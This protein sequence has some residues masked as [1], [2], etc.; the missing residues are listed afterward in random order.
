MSE[1]PVAPKRSSISPSNLQRR[2][3]CPGSLLAE[4]GLPE[5]GDPKDALKGTEL[6]DLDEK[7]PEAW[8][9]IPERD[10]QLLE[11]NKGLRDAFLTEQLSKRGVNPH[12]PVRVFKEHE[13]YFCDELGMPVEDPDEIPGHPDIIYYFP[14]QKLAFIFDSKFGGLAVPKAYMNLQLRSYAVMFSD[15]Y[16]VDT[17]VA[18]ITQPMLQEPDDFHAVEFKGDEM[19]KYRG[20]ILQVVAACQKPDA[21]RIPSAEACLHCKAKAHCA[22]AVSVL[23][24]LSM[25]TVKGLSIDE[26]EDIYDEYVAKSKKVIDAIINRMHYLA[27]KGALKRHRLGRQTIERKVVDSAE[28]FNKCFEAGG[29]LHSDFEEAQKEWNRV[30]EVSR[31]QLEIMCARNRGTTQKE[32]RNLIAEVCGDLIEEKPRRASIERIPGT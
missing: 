24:E 30:S 19:E 18:A 20:Q 15:E 25:M 26:L 4:E 9:G 3:L 21:P 5:L 8:K 11:K 14:D 2:H 16:D 7:G 13:L 28:A 27:E 12:S 6:H 10:L 1:K 32:M 17:I 23:E 22:E 29:I 31:S